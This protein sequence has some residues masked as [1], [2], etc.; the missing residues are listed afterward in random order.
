MERV[1]EARKQREGSGMRTAVSLCIGLFAPRVLDVAPCICVRQRLSF[2]LLQP[3]L[4]L[5][6][7]RLECRGRLFALLRVAAHGVQLLLH[8][9]AARVELGLCGQQVVDQ[10]RLQAQI[11][12]QHATQRHGQTLHQLILASGA[13]IGRRVGC[14]GGMSSVRRCGGSS[15]RGGLSVGR[16]LLLLLHWLL[17][18]D[19][20]ALLL[21][22]R[23][24]EYGRVG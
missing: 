15:G 16:G 14:R 6:T 17:L 9:L 3:S 12:R 20:P 8:G 21:C 19:W 18:C 13:R 23:H 11:V 2:I 24:F 1:R 10:Q 5:L 7:P 22:C 4:E